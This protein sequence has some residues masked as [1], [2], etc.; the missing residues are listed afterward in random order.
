MYEL[1]GRDRAA[2][3]AMGEAL[4]P[5]IHPEDRQRVTERYEL[6]AAS[7]GEFEL[8]FRILTEQGEERVLHA[9]GREDPSAPGCYVGTFQDVTEQRRAELAEAANRAKSEFLARMS[10][11]LRTPLNSII[12]FSQLLELDGLAPAIGRSGDPA[13][14]IQRQSGSHS[15]AAWAPPADPALMRPPSAE[16]IPMR[17]ARV[18]AR[19]RGYRRRTPGDLPDQASSLAA[20]VRHGWVRKQIVAWLAPGGGYVLCYERHRRG[21]A[22]PARRHAPRVNRVQVVCSGWIVLICRAIGASVGAFWQGYARGFGR[23]SGELRRK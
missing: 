14:G 12:G 2:G 13:G 21:R 10:H 8:D 18:A 23:T 7:E 22:S 17:S 9:V 6:G 1:P 3:P 11:E 15:R 20:R 19:D 5:Y 16:T 4:L